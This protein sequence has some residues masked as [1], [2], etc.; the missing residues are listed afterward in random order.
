MMH[1][2]VSQETCSFHSLLQLIF[3]ITNVSDS[4]QRT[5]FFIPSIQ[6]VT[7][8]LMLLWY[9]HTETLLVML[10]DGWEVKY[11]LCRLIRTK[12]L[13]TLYRSTNTF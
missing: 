12:D 7:L 1:N 6:L 5:L 8:I 4:N 9:C 2:I 11:T 13:P 10:C 3:F